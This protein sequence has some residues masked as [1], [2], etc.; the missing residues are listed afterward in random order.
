MSGQNTL[1]RDCPICGSAQK[2]DLYLQSFSGLSRGTLLTGY[3]VVV[4]GVCG[5][6]YAHDVPEQDAFEAYYRNMSKY[7][8]Q[9]SRG[10]GIADLERCQST[11]DALTRFLPGR[12][13]HV[14]DIGCATGRILGLLKAR[15]Y[16]NVLG[17]DPSRECVRLAAELY[18]VK[19]LPHTISTMPEWRGRFDVVLLVSV[20]EHVQHLHTLIERVS[21]MLVPQGLLLIEH[22]DV[23]RFSAHANGPFQ[24]FSTEHINFF[25]RDSLANLLLQHG[26][27]E[28]YSHQEDRSTADGVLEP[29]SSSIFRKSGRKTA[30]IPDTETK[31][32]LLAYITESE[33]IATDIKT[34]INQVVDNEKPIIV[35]GVG[36]HTQRLMATT[37]LAFARIVAFVDSNPR[38]HD[39]QLHGVPI[40]P[41]ERLAGRGEPIL[42]SSNVWQRDIARQIR[43]SGYA[44]ELI[45]LYPDPSEPMPKR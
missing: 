20:V 36:A 5:F 11:V 16:S 7:E 1:R 15:G 8:Q 23:R 21:T 22:P 19:V 42:I 25:S 30:I 29:S 37:R 44:N 14:L 26:F 6:A 3:L 17:I 32:A 9:H 10:G 31:W 39:K 24:E 27:E 38:Y 33:R 4:C 45:L 13:A 34:V 2:T 28:V 35:W 12:D 18:G 41:P 43:T 40:L